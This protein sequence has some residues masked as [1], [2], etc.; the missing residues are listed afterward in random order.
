MA[1]LFSLITL[2]GA[3]LLLWTPQRAW[4]CPVCFGDPNSPMAIGASWGIA[5]LLGVTLG[6]LA[7]FAG[8]FLYLLKRS[9]MA[10]GERI[11]LSRSSQA[12]GSV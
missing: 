6:V 12:S 9:R 1:R 4:A 11:E 2:M 10:L 3:A 7:V 5:L 8:F